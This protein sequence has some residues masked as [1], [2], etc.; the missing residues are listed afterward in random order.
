MVDW[1]RSR[2]ARSA[3]SSSRFDDQSLIVALQHRADY[4]VTPFDAQPY[5]AWASSV[6][7]GLGP[8]FSH[9]Y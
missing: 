4:E 7:A 3:I 8:T 5:R 1:P 6:R 9:I 2:A